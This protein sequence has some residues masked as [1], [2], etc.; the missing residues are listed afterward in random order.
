MALA[1]RDYIHS[2]KIK[3]LIFILRFVHF[4]IREVFCICSAV[5]LVSF[6]RTLVPIGLLA[7]AV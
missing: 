6:T 1:Y 7:S 5:S 2:D 3:F 4:L